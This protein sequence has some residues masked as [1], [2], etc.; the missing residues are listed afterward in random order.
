MQQHYGVFDA[1]LVLVIVRIVVV[2]LIV[3]LMTW[4]EIAILIAT[5]Q[6]PQT[7]LQAYALLKACDSAILMSLIVA[8]AQA[9]S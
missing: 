9:V 6:K 4:F 8:V 2:V 3:P 5:N 1:V 7:K